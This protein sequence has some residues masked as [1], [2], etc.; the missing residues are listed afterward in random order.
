MRQAIITLPNGCQH[1]ISPKTGKPRREAV[2]L[3][4][5]KLTT[6]RRVLFVL[7]GNRADAR[8]YSTCFDFYCVS[9]LHATKTQ[10]KGRLIRDHFGTKTEDPKERFMARVR[11]TEDCW[12]FGRSQNSQRY[13]LYQ[14][15]RG[16]SPIPAHRASHLL[17]IGP[18]PDGLV[19]CH[20][21]NTPQCVRPEH[22]YAGT[23]AE[24]HRDSV[25]AGTAGH[26]Q[27]KLGLLTPR[28]GMMR[29]ITECS[30]CHVRVDLYRHQA[31]K[32]R[33]HHFCGTGCRYKWMAQEGK[34]LIDERL[35]KARA[36]KLEPN[37]A[38]S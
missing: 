15:G 13:G 27:R 38:G 12:L 19:V 14:P 6:I 35:A 21:C 34:A 37:Q 1:Y 29:C 8:L 11:K 26:V 10:P 28:R 2:I 9:P 4:R 20:R 5:G 7:A 16:A 31:K 25:V 17:F 18:I 23:L 33:K 22:L 24:N 36:K 32:N 3:F 30:K